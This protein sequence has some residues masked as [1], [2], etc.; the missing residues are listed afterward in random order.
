MSDL[1]R[2][3]IQVGCA[4]VVG[5]LAGSSYH[6]TMGVADFVKDLLSTCEEA[7]SIEHYC[8]ELGYYIEGDKLEWRVV[9]DGWDVSLYGFMDEPEEEWKARIAQAEE[10]KRKQEEK[11]RKQL[12]ELMKKYPDIVK[13][14]K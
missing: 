10:K 4:Y 3:K 9:V 11:E 7:K 12:Q 13:K 14:E 1:E 2:K 5:E 6:Y 8:D